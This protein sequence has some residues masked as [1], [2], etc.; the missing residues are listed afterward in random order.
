MVRVQLRSPKGSNAPWTG[1]IV[2]VCR[3]DVTWV[4]KKP[5][6][7]PKEEAALIVTFLNVFYGPRRRPR[8]RLQYLP[9][10]SFGPTR[11]AVEALDGKILKEDPSLYEV[12]E[13]AIP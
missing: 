3:P 6:N 10:P 4:V 1:K 12:R 8:N 7:L 5:K 2:A 11:A 13:G 9:Y